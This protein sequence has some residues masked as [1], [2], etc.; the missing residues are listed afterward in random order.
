MK[1]LIH[2]LPYC[3][4]LLNKYYEFFVDMKSEGCVKY[5]QKNS[6]IEIILSI[7]YIIE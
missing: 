5:R 7:F 1:I 4:K 2:I 6:I 3:F